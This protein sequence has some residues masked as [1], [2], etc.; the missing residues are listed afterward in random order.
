M[1][2]ALLT[3]GIFF[4]IQNLYSQ[5]IT[6][7]I[8]ETKSK[9]YYEEI[10]FEFIEDKVIIPVEIQGKAYRFI[11]DTGAPNMISEEIY[12]AINP[13]LINSVLVKDAN[14]KADT[15]KIVSVEKIK[16]GNITFEK[17]A[18]LVYDTKSTLLKCFN[19]DGLIGSNML[20]N[21]IIQVDTKKNLL[22]LTDNRNRLDLNKQKSGNIELLGIQSMPYVWLELK[23]EETVS[24]QL[25]IDLGASGTYDIS[26]E[27]FKIFEQN[28]VFL[29]FNKNILI[30]TLIYLFIK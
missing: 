9:D 20:R 1:K 12:Q 24:E 22:I 29:N 28:K 10:S 21:S 14:E 4:F 6:L 30:Y 3:F 13:E 8:G 17:V 2:V 25:V 7:N 16:L 15:L 11:L 27:H 5:N 18:T 23:G 26:Q 19:V